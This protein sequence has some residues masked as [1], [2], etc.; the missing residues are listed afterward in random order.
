[1]ISRRRV[2]AARA[3]FCLETRS[4]QELPMKPSALI[5]ISILLLFAIPQ[6][7]ALAADNDA[8]LIRD[9][10]LYLDNSGL[11]CLYYQ[12]GISYYELILPG[13]C[14]IT[15]KIYGCDS[16]VRL[17]VDNISA[18][19][20]L[21]YT[22]SISQDTILSISA[23]DS[24]FQSVYILLTLAAAQPPPPPPPPLPPP[25]PPPDQKTETEAPP[26]EPEP[27]QQ[28]ADA[29]AGED[30]A[31]P[32]ERHTLLLQIDEPL[33]MLDGSPYP[34]DT[35]PFILPPGHTMVPL[36]FIAEALGGVVYWDPDPGRVDIYFNGAYIALYIGRPLPGTEISAMIRDGRTFVPLRYV[37]ETLGAYVEWI[38]EGKYIF[39]IYPA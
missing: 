20:S 2:F 3:F 17:K 35:A 15:L 24:A 10:D 5:L 1:M 34:L 29:P 30:A 11:D 38:G 22:R 6:P 16:N 8:G 33:M 7:L 25:P 36:R 31:E 4:I 23:S 27:P 13:S 32:I 9:I 14:Q 12:S 26:P 39:I 21:T 18:Q 28:A 19:G 37:M